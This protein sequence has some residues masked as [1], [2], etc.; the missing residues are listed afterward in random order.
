MNLQ[1]IGQDLSVSSHSVIAVDGVS[2][3]RVVH[4]L[5]GLTNLHEHKQGFT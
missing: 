3:H 5:W 2:V 1:Q 4:V